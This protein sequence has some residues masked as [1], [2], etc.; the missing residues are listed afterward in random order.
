VA[1][2]ARKWRVEWFPHGKWEL[3][4]GGLSKARAT[5]LAD[6][7]TYV[8]SPR[9]W[10]EVNNKM[11]GNV[12]TRVL[13]EPVSSGLVENPE[14]VDEVVAQNHRELTYRAPQGAEVVVEE[15][16]GHLH[17]P[18]LG[19]GAYGCVF[20]TTA[21]GI[22]LKITSDP[23]EATF[24]Q[25]LKD[26]GLANTLGITRYYGSSLLEGRRQGRALYA[27]WREEADDVGELVA[28]EPQESPKVTAKGSTRKTPKP[29]VWAALPLD[30][31][32]LET[33][34]EARRFADRLAEYRWYASSVRHVVDNAQD[35]DRTRARAAELA[36]WASLL[37]LEGAVYNYLQDL[38][39]K[40]TILDE[41][42]GPE[43]M[44]LALRG[45]QVL[46]EAMAGESPAGALVG[47]SFL[48]MQGKGIV[49]ADVHGGNVGRVLRPEQY[50][51]WRV[52]VVTDP[53]HMVRI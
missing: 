44:A 12:P 23:T 39:M 38:R 48:E 47:G 43:R 32:R 8:L 34:V 10:D 46:A 40:P 19:C 21:P 3:Y 5:R 49:L 20:R 17:A 29:R 4:S 25:V 26:K 14:W 42:R 41:H 45:C 37:D 22:V 33:P 16:E 1:G 36:G 6:Q 28:R 27:L 18:E 24:V 51:R 2:P 52:W 30:P 15:A 7:V 31:P 50:G 9:W 35:Q 13:E 53:G 11:F